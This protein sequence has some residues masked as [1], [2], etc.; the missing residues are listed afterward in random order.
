[1][2]CVPHAHALRQRL[3]VQLLE[4]HPFIHARILEAISLIGAR[5]VIATRPAS[6]RLRLSPKSKQMAPKSKEL[7]AGLA[8]ITTNRIPAEGNGRTARS[9]AGVQGGRAAGR[10]PR[11]RSS[12]PRAVNIGEVKTWIADCP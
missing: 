1:M 2:Q 10:S 9:P 12:L 6:E 8:Y 3:A 7:R 4:D 11:G 5:N